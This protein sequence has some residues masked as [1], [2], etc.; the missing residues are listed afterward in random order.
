MTIEKIKKAEVSFF[1]KSN[2]RMDQTSPLEM[3]F[4][5]L[6]VVVIAGLLVMTSITVYAMTARVALEQ[7]WGYTDA[8][9]DVSVLFGFIAMCLAMRDIGNKEYCES[10]RRYL[11]KRLFW[12]P[13]KIMGISV[14]FATLLTLIHDIF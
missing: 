1:G 2:K 4:L 3:L 12:I 14:G 8:G 11:V 9:W 13:V 7:I 5:M 6:L 10:T